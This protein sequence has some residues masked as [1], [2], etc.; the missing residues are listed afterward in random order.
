MNRKLCKTI[1]KT[2]NCVTYQHAEDDDST[3][4]FLDWNC[5]RCTFLNKSRDATCLMCGARAESTH[6]PSHHTLGDFLIKATAD[7]MYKSDSSSG[8]DFADESLQRA[9]ELSLAENKTRNNIATTASFATSQKKQRKTKNKASTPSSDCDEFEQY[10]RECCKFRRRFDRQRQKARALFNRERLD[11]CVNQRQ[12]TTY[13]PYGPLPAHAQYLLHTKCATLRALIPSVKSLLQSMR[14]WCDVEVWEWCKWY[15]KNVR[16]TRQRLIS[17]GDERAEISVSVKTVLDPD[18]ML[19]FVHRS[20]HRKQH[21]KA[22]DIGLVYTHA[23]LTNL[24]QECEVA[25]KSR[26]TLQHASDMIRYFGKDLLISGFLRQFSGDTVYAD[27][28]TLCLRYYHLH[29]AIHE[30]SRRY[31]RNERVRCF[32]YNSTVG[33]R[34]EFYL[35]LSVLWDGHDKDVQLYSLLPVYR[36]TVESRESPGH[37]RRWLGWFGE[38]I[39]KRQP[40]RYVMRKWSAYHKLNRIRM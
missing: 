10:W 24:E 7:K 35:C 29:G 28:E 27:V 26:S 33:R 22:K 3:I 8:G 5:T 13:T 14:V 18:A 39:R 32:K 4:P 1:T 12:L 34:E 9:I 2:H 37:S 17:V 16:R 23:E 25:L 21:K 6:T 30:Y 15:G 19:R 40:H 36:V 11:T 38:E 31:T 20:Q